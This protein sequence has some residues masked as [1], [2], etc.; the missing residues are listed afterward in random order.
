MIDKDCFVIADTHFGHTNINMY[1]PIRKK[2]SSAY[3]YNDPDGYLI[4]A[5]NQ[6]VSKN[7]TVFHLGDFCFIHNNIL[8]LSK[9][10]Q[11]KKILLVGNHDKLKDIEYLKKDGWR[12]IDTIVIDLD[13]RYEVELILKLKNKQY[14]LSKKLQKLLCCYI[15]DI[16]EK[17]VMFSHFPLFDDNEHD[18]KFKPITDVLEEI[19]LD[20]NC[21]HN[22]H[23]HI[24]SKKA[25]ESCCINVSVENFDLKP[26]K[27]KEAIK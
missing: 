15:C 17:R 1:E 20:L 4:D 10:L 25:K 11:G 14:S 27:I 18:V 12:I 16:E 9:S 13:N 19:Y 3:G 8:S 23:G 26:V 7:D 21:T 5:W 2:V 6:T 24:H 22:V